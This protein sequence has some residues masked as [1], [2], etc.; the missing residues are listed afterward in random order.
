M[1]GVYYTETEFQD[2]T[3]ITMEV[4]GCQVHTIGKA[5]RLLFADPITFTAFKMKHGNGILL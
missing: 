2:G 3:L 4:I 1:L 5:V